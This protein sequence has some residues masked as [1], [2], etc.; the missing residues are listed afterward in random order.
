MN[1]PTTLKY[2]RSAR[3]ETQMFVPVHINE[4]DLENIQVK[5]YYNNE[6]VFLLAKKIRGARLVPGR[7]YELEIK[8]RKWNEYNIIRYHLSNTL[9]TLK[10]SKITDITSNQQKNV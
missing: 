1:K 10:L 2:I 5:P 6:Y 9:E 4:N 3:Y 8:Q 7:I